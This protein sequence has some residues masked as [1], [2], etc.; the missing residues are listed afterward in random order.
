[1]E[2]TQYDG[3]PEWIW[4][5]SYSRLHVGFG[6]HHRFRTRISGICLRNLHSF[7][8]INRE[9]GRRPVLAY[10]RKGGIAHDRH[11]P[12]TRAAIHDIA[13]S[14]ERTQAGFLQNVLGI[15]MTS[16]DAVGQCIGIGEM[17]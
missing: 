4:Q 16:C 11:D 12:R 10:P 13:D 7:E 9:Y 15:S 2:I 5:S 17:R 14:T 3:F 8:I 6:D 1:M